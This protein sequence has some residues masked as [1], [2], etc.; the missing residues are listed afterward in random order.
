M[1]PV[2]IAECCQNH[3]GSRSTLQRMIHAATESG[4]DYVKIQALHSSEITFRKRFEDGIT[5]ADGTVEVIRRPYGAEVDRL[6]KLDLT[7]DDEAWFV[8][9][10]RR[11]GVRSMITVFT[12]HGAA[13]LRDVGF[14]A[15]KVA[16]YD[17][18]SFPLLRDIRQWWSTIV[19]S[20]GATYDSEIAGAAE[21]LAGC[22]LTLL[23]CVTLYP[24]PMDQLHLRRM[25]FLRRFTPQVGYS[26]HTAPGDTGLWASKIALAL[27]ADA[28]ERHFTVLD[29][30]ETRDGPVSI[31]PA[32]LAEL[33]AFADLPRAERMAHVHKEQPD[34]ETTLGEAQRD[35]SHAEL[36]NRDYYAGRVASKVAG[37]DVFNWEDVDL[38]VDTSPP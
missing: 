10:C 22:D 28:I 25:S 36:L 3:Q 4:A 20:T 31:D 29:R 23:H 13:R 26:D 11:A 38:G 18:R 30:S 7:P 33:R 27:G 24:T 17:C 21:I 37:R 16:S 2:L 6:S 12:R 5:A 32:D 9:E 19:V 34:W 15:V 8:D 35:L 1:R 14:D